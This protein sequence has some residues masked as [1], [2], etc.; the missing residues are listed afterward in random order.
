MT[1]RCDEHGRLQFGPVVGRPGGAP[2]RESVSVSESTVAGAPHVWVTVI[3]SESHQVWV[4][5]TMED[6]TVLR[7][8]LTHLIEHRVG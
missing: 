8:Q 6:A 7:D 3:D 4:H 5:L 2:P 1:G